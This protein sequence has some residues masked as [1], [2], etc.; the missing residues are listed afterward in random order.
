L[1]L[2]PRPAFEEPS[3]ALRFPELLELAARPDEIAWA[4][5]LPGVDIFRLYTEPNG[6]S[7]ALIRFQPGAR[8]PLH[9]HTGVEHILVLRGSQCD[10]RG[11]A[12]IGTLIVNRPGSRHSIVSDSGCVVLAI[13]EKPVRFIDANGTPHA[14]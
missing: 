6:R 10:E 11:L 4:A 8:V 13:Y 3:T 2:P 14:D 12:S 1:K 7:A 5:Y 9:E